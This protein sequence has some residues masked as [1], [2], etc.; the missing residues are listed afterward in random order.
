LRCSAGSSSL[1]LILIPVGQSDDHEQV[2][3]GHATA[4]GV[5]QSE[6]EREERKVMRREENRHL[7]EHNKRELE[8]ARHRPLGQAQS[9]PQLR[10]QI[11][12]KS[13][14][15]ASVSSSNRSSAMGER[16]ADQQS[17]IRA[18]LS[19]PKILRNDGLGCR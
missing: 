10:R 1:G 3:A 2:L 15:I 9:F 8:Y 11:Y 12:D 17:M 7:R 13:N 5:H 18:Q 4:H 14:M 19:S 6:R 16:S